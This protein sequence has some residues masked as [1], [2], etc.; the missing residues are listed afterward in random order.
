LKQLLLCVDDER[1]VLEGIRSQIKR[2]LPRSIQLELAESAE[3]ALEIL[4]E[5]SP[6][7]QGF[8]MII[9]DHIMPGM[10]G[11]QLLINIHQRFPHTIKILLTGQADAHS[12][13]NALNQGGLYRYIS[14]PWEEQ[15]LMMTITGGLERFENH[16]EIESKTQLIKEDKEAFFRFVPE[17]FLTWMGEQ[18][19][20]YQH[21]SS[22]LHST[23]D[24]AVM[25]L[26][27]RS[28][29][30]L[31]ELME[32]DDIFAFLE[33][34]F[35][36]FGQEIYEHEGL[37]EKYMGDAILALFNSS[38]RAVNAAR[39][40]QKQLIKLNEIRNQQGKVQIKVGIGIHSGEVIIG[41]LGDEYRLQ[42]TV[43]GDCVNIAARLEELTKEHGTGI[44]ISERVRQSL[45]DPESFE[46]VG[47]LTLRGR[48]STLKVYSD[49]ESS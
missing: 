38:E 5:Y 21:L 11:D 3:D 28:F 20:D 8:P 41:T 40:I 14:K 10:K 31:C 9:T 29:T 22:G 26:D 30:T 46:N 49:S 24:L 18:S 27:I 1:V 2:Y 35:T 6:A 43:L 4:E 36:G 48:F 16:W 15:D 33:D 34:L 12:V 39:G 25:F 47:S 17:K 37:I 32:N 13:G 45:K 7:P 42:T 23:V 19:Q 44:L